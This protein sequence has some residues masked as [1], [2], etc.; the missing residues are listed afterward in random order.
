MAAHTSMGYRQNRL[1][2]P[3]Q[4]AGWGGSRSKSTDTGVLFSDLSLQPWVSCSASPPGRHEEHSWTLKC[5]SWVTA[6]VGPWRKLLHLQPLLP[7]EGI[8]KKVLPNIIGFLRGFNKTIV[9]KK[10]R[11]TTN[12]N[13][14]LVVYIIYRMFEWLQIHDLTLTH[15]N[16][17]FWR[18]VW[19]NQR[20]GPYKS[21]YAFEEEKPLSPKFC[22]SILPPPH[23]SSPPAGT[24]QSARK[25][26]S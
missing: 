1:K 7:Y 17:G 6:G 12:D 13:L 25:P 20:V 21:S 23:P 10:A 15:Q 8:K 19:G 26:H 18:W 14:F 9:F 11:D 3:K 2:H 22:S 16:N 5:E 4:S 24:K